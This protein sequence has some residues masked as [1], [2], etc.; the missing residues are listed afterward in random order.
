MFDSEPPPGRFSLKDQIRCVER[1]IAMRKA[2]Y[3]GFVQRGK[4]MAP[5]AE[6]EIACMEQVLRTL[7]RLLD[8]GR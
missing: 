7:N 1:E 4:L 5:V 8:D 2:A 3:P 6:R